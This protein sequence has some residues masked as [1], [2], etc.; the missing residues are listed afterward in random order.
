MKKLPA[1]QSFPCI[2]T[3]KQNGPEGSWYEKGC[4]NQSF[5]GLYA[6]H[7]KEDT[8]ILLT[9]KRLLDDEQE[10]DCPHA[11]WVYSKDAD[12]VMWT[13]QPIPN[14]KYREGLSGLQLEVK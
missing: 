13:S 9:S 12:V 1:D 8:N 5:R 10:I 14:A 11:G 6:S 3:I 2:F 4:V 7:H